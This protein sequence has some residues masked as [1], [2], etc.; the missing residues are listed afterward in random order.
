MLLPTDLLE[1]VVAQSRDLRRLAQ[2]AQVCWSWRRAAAARRNQLRLLRHLGSWG[3][4]GRGKEQIHHAGA[5][6][7]VRLGPEAN[8]AMMV[9]CEENRLR[10]LRQRDRAERTFSLPGSVSRCSDL[11]PL[12]R[13]AC[14]PSGVA[15]VRTAPQRG[16]LYVSDSGADRL[17]RLELDLASISPSG[18]PEARLE[19]SVGRFGTRADGGELVA[20]GALAFW[21][22]DERALLCVCNGDHVSFFDADLGFRFAL[23]GRGSARGKFRGAADLAVCGGELWVA[24]ERNHRLQAFDDTGAH[25]RGFGSEG[26]RPGQ[27][28]RPHAV[29]SCRGALVVSEFT[30][31]R[32]QV[33]TTAGEPMQLL[34]A[35][36]PCRGV[37]V[38]PLLID[39]AAGAA[40]AAA[41]APAPPMHVFE[42]LKER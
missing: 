42:L 13:G 28:R 40:Y 20:P 30:G 39:E 38:G 10:W 33:L 24:D 9:L 12:S 19:L 7:L 8:S 5:A 36:G 11:L 29:S 22:R 35:C 34:S 1:H 14:G 18:A 2:I 21:E 15:F 17:H 16:H 41:A 6:A 27:F 37:R 32:V 25:V 31:K 26:V 3:E 23:G 4:R